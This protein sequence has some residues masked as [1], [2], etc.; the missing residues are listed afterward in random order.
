MIKIKYMKTLSLTLIMFFSAL[1]FGQKLNVDS[2]KH[3]PEELIQKVLIT[4][5]VKVSG[6]KFTGD[7]RAVAFF[8]EG[9]TAICFES[10]ILLSSGKATNA[11]GPNNMAGKA[12][13]FGTKGDKD[14]NKLLGSSK[15]KDAAV[16]EF[17][18]VSQS[19]SIKFEYIFASEEYPEYVGQSYNDVFGFFLSGKN[20]AGGKYENVNLAV[21]PGTTTAIAINNVNANKNKNY[22]Y[23]NYKGE[24]IQFDGLTVPLIARKAVV[25][26]ETYH[27][28]LAIS[29]VSDTNYDSGVFL[30]AASFFSGSSFEFENICLGTETEFKLSNPDGIKT[31]KWD[32]GDPDSGSNNTLT[33][34]NPKHKFSKAGTYTVKLETSDGSLTNE[35]EETITIL[36]KEFCISGKSVIPEGESIELDAGSGG[37]SYKWSNGETTQK[38]TVNKAGTYT[39]EIAY[40]GQCRAKA[41]KTVTLKDAKNGCCIPA[42]I[43][44][45][46]IFLTSLLLFFICK[47]KSEEL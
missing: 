4:G 24:N 7:K 15:S 22:Y 30:K 45:G 16:L 33:E 8:S 29:D 1:S 10:G 3:S 13:A 42:L 14:L 47:K 21:L 11:V 46:L 5:S 26:G 20:P 31:C 41:S 35:T 25:K 37:E 38:I 17:D 36:G 27:I 32:F 39:V 18:F 9:D 19:D 12:T 6:I 43:F 40:G 44:A 2:K 23:N 34:F 28:K